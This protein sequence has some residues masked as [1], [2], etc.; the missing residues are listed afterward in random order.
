[1]IL[2]RLVHATDTTNSYALLVGASRYEHLEERWKLAGPANDVILMQTVLI[3]R[4]MPAANIRVLSDSAGADSRPTRA[5]ILEELDRLG[6][7]VKDG[8]FVMIH[9]AGHGSQQ[10]D[11]QDD[12]ETD[13]LDELFLPTDVEGWNGQR[14]GVENA[15]VDDELGPRLKSI[16]NR[17]AFVWFVADSCFS[18][19]MVRGA[20]V[21]ERERLITP[22]AL[23]IPHDVLMRAQA[24][25][26][27]SRGAQAEADPLAGVAGEA[28]RGGFVAFYAAQTTETT[29]EM[30]FGAS[31]ADGER[32]WYGLFSYNLASI[33]AAHPNATYR[34]VAQQIF[35]N[36][37]AMN[38]HAPTPLLEGRP[39]DLDR[40]ALG[41]GG[42]EAVR[43]WPVEQE[44]PGRLR[45]SAGRLHQIFPGMIVAVLP[46]AAET[47]RETLLGY[48]RVADAGPTRSTLVPIAYE[49]LEAVYEV[50]EQAQAR[51]VDVQVRNELSYALAPEEAT[52][53]RETARQ[54]LE[55]LENEDDGLD[56][57]QVD[58]QGSPNLRLLVA[59]GRLWFLPP[60]GAIDRTPTSGGDAT[61]PVVRGQTPSIAIPE[62]AQPDPEEI[63]VFRKELRES[64]ETVAR[65][66]TL[67][68]L[69][70]ALG[71]N[72]LA[73]NLEISPEVRRSDGSREPFRLNH[74]PPRLNDGDVLVTRIANKGQQ[75]VDLTVLFVDSRY[76]IEPWFP[77]DG[78]SN[79]LRHGEHVELELG[80]TL[81]TIGLEHFVFI[82][83]AAEPQAPPSDLTNLA[84]KQLP[85]RG[86]AIA[87]LQDMLP[88][89][90]GG[91]RPAIE[92]A[93]VTVFSWE[94]SP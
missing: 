5:A 78:R 57:M 76:G 86:Q 15:I 25:G 63:A 3:D 92:T 27:A 55:R 72:E 10:P 88:T 90:R 6:R 80:V 41:G 26:S 71:G 13:G 83:V 58:W 84:Q 73:G 61:G 64:L 60:S 46:V 89:T 75:V 69:A 22:E 17:G 52:A 82:A 66:T 32:P 87:T 29:P 36:Y 11:N 53:A 37:R 30:R 21:D 24:D 31:G 94:V 49:G 81:S 59:D 47:G 54:E 34:Q 67:F 2:T 9:L 56:L 35:S 39:D 4:G 40:V 93:A 43:Q 45:L 62:A 7:T 74:V 28:E 85:V 51:V 18:G 8:D 48:A 12:D 70:R 50:P 19:T 79:R 91:N 65:V 20:P 44:R 42:G 23:G 38:R 1:M 16:Q 14:G 77:F 33:I 68:N